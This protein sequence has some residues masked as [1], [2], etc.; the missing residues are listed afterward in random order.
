V[1]Y[2]TSLINPEK[3]LTIDPQDFD[4]TALQIFHYHMKTISYIT[5]IAMHYILIYQL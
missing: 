2:N 4:D 5:N 3:L 1:F